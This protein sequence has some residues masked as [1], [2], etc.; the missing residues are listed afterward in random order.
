LEKGWFHLVDTSK[1]RMHFHAV[2]LSK[3]ELPIPVFEAKHCVEGQMTGR[4]NAKR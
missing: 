4:D 2:F 3:A 1:S